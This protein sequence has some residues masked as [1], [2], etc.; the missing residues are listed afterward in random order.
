MKKIKLGIT[1]G[2]VN[3]VGLE[4]ILKSISNN[5]VLKH[6]SPII[7]G[8]A[9]IVSYHKNIIGLDNLQFKTV[10][11]AEVA[12]KDSINLVS[13]WDENVNI[14]LGKPTEEGG[15]FAKMAIEKAVTDL[16]NGDIDALVTGPINKDAMH[17]AGFQYIGH[18]EMLTEASGKKESLMFMVSDG[19]RVGLVTNHEQI[20]EV[21]KNITKER[22]LHKLHLMNES[23]IKDFGIDKPKIAVLGL[24]PHAGDGGTI[25]KEDEE[26]VRP[27]VLEAKKNGM[28]TFGPYPADG[29]FGA[30]QFKKFDA[31]LAM[32]HDQGLIPFKSLTFGSGVNFTAGLNFIRTS[33]DHGTA[34]DIVGQNI[35][36]PTSFR[37]AIY[38]A[39][40]IYRNRKSYKEMHSDKLVKRSGK[41]AKVERGAV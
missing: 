24:N 38:T 4:V 36:D 40:D 34:Y 16:A 6:I 28:M 3:G 21:A 22:I 27:A 20:K 39:I 10:D 1:I 9:K 15:K 14:T 5:N 7:Y 30:A 8:S 13:C 35:A 11:R 37:N 26:I 25:G 19:I 41:I 23:L 31:V 32:Y 33:P 12:Y 17:Q 29:F 2:D 18:T